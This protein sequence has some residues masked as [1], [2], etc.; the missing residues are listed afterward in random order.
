MRRASAPMPSIATD[1]KRSSTRSAQ[2]ERRASRSGKNSTRRAPTNQPR[3]T[4]TT[5]QLIDR[6]HRQGKGRTV[7]RGL[8]QSVHETEVEHFLANV[9]SSEHCQLNSTVNRR[10][11]QSYTA[12]RQSPSRM[13]RRACNNVAQRQRSL[14]RPKLLPPDQRHVLPKQTS[15]ALAQQ[16]NVHAPKEQW[17]LRR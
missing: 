11:D 1:G 6:D 15:R 5:L 17:L 16:E 13:E 8:V 10:P 14:V 4:T 7:P 3:A 9:D 12:H 2:T